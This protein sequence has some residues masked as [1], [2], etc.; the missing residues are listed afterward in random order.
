MLRRRKKRKHSHYRDRNCQGLSQH[1]EQ[2]LKLRLRKS[3]PS[4]PWVEA[5]I[6]VVEDTDA[7][8]RPIRYRL[9]DPSVF[10]P[11]QEQTRMMRCRK[12]GVF[13]PPNAMEG[14]YCL[15][16]SRHKAWGRSLSAIAIR[17]LERRKVGIDFC[18]LLPEDAESLQLEIDRF[19]RKQL[20]IAGEPTVL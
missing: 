19:K 1:R 13:T 3:S 2:M 15:D 20:K 9:H 8:G 4:E 10:P 14:G 11:G 18:P 17:A 5:Q 16:H 12:C 7:D 6:V